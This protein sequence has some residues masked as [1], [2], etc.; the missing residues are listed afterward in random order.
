MKITF[1]KHS[2]YSVETENYF[3]IFDYIGGSI[4]F[5]EDKKIIFIATHRH[6]DHFDPDIFSYNAD[7]FILS[8][9]IKTEYP[10]N[11]FFI[12][13][14]NEYEVSGLKIKTTGSTDEG[15]AIYVNADNI[16]IIHSGD[17][18]HW[19]WDR[20]SKEEQDHMKIWFESEVDKFKN[21]KVDVV[22]MVVDP[23]MKDSYYLTGEYFLE[24]IDAKYY[25]PMHMWEDFKISKKFNK[26]YKDLYKN[27]EIIIINHDN[28]EFDLKI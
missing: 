19:V 10:K 17:L 4:N 8:D 25:F 9:D 3:L 12:S 16:G 20:Y 6:K 13:P 15:V 23:R 7:L 5:P 26:K 18:N 27:K 1:I 2:C 24:N 14:D 28:E 22:F 21:E 11:T